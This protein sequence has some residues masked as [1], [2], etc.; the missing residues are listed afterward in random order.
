MASTQDEVIQQSCSY[1]AAAAE[2]L[3]PSRAA[4]QLLIGRNALIVNA[5]SLPT[6]F[7][8]R[9]GITLLLAQDLPLYLEVSGLGEVRAN[10]IL[11]PP[12]VKR[13]FLSQQR[14][15]SI[16]VEPGHPHYRSALS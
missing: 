15:I 13:R 3:E 5:N 11:L 4:N 9:P 16:T 6:G 1:P 10:A 14:H 7:N 2:S 8:Q 12:E